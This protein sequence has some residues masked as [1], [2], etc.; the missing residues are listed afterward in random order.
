MLT[1]TEYTL[2]IASR[3]E[4][5]SQVEPLIE[6]VRDQFNIDDELY[7]NILVALTEAVNNAILHGNKSEPDKK[8]TI[9]VRNDTH[10]IYFIVSDEGT[11]FD[12]NNLPDPTA[13]ENLE[14]PTGRGVFLMTNLAD[15]VIFSENGRVVEIQ[16]RY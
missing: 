7:G 4:N 3:P 15:M 6:K 1:D 9:A 11:G 10:H 14:K 5:V 8:V 16:F 2:E 13:P 12:Y